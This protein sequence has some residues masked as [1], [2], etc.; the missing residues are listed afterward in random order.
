MQD[1]TVVG[2]RYSVYTRIVLICLAE[3]GLS[4]RLHEIDIFD[5]RDRAGHF[6]LH[7]FG[8]I[9]VLVHDGKPVIETA[10]IVRLVDRLVPQPPL[11]PAD[12]EDCAIADQVIEVVNSYA[13]RHLVWGVY[14]PWQR[15]SEAGAGPPDFAAEAEADAVSASLGFLERALAGRPMFGGTG[16]GAADAFAYAVLAYFRRVPWGSERLATFGELSDWMARVAARDSVV[17]TR[18]PSETES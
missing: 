12:A 6:G 1:L 10:A 14:V 16:F 2:A 3:K 9:P 18:Y 7:P 17:R 4:S 11:F 13:Y 5:P 8:K 15:A